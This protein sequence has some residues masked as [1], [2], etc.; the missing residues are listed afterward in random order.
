[1]LPVNREAAGPVSLAS[2]ESWIELNIVPRRPL[3]EDVLVDLVDPLVHETFAAEIATW[4]FL[5]EP[6]LRLRI[7]W[8]DGDRAAEL[9][10]LLTSVLDPWKADRKLDD[11]YEGAHGVRGERYVG[12]ADHYGEEIWPRLQLDWMS[13]SE[14]ALALVKVDRARRLTRPRDYH[15]NRRVHLF[16][17]QLLQTWDA[18]VE[19]SLRQALGYLKLLGSPTREMKR[20]IA[21]LDDVARRG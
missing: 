4:F 7:R 14:L 20:L 8:R 19:L 1:M 16:T 11:W 17:N 6:E 12:E 10:D 9:R 13:G 18:E 15:W 3:D 5:W 21:E 2:V